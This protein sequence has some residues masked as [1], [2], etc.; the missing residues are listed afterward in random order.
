MPAAHAQ[1]KEG[2]CFAGSR[3][4]QCYI[5]VAVSRSTGHSPGEPFVLEI[6]PAGHFSPIHSHGLA[7]GVTRI[8]HGSLTC[9]PSLT[10]WSPASDEMLV[11]P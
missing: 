11:A 3:R 6:W 5:R 4:K 2:K 10:L 7:Y 9:E 1:A 8:L